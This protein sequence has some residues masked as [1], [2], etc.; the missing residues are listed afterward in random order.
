MKKIYVIILFIFLLILAGIFLLPKDETN[1][2]YII[3]QSYGFV[4]KE[5]KKAEIDVYTKLKRS[6]IDNAEAN[7]YYLT[8]DTTRYKLSGIEVYKSKLNGY[9]IYKISFTLPDTK[10]DI[11]TTNAYLSI[12][13]ER[14]LEFHLSSLSI[15]YNKSLE[16]SF[17]TIYATYGYINGALMLVGINIELENKYNILSYFS[18]NDFSY[19]DMTCIL[20]ESLQNN[21]VNIK[22]LL[23]NYNYN[24]V[25]FEQMEIKSN[26][27]FIPV[28]YNDLLMIKHGYIILKLDGQKYI[29]NDFDFIFN[30]LDISEYKDYM[31]EV[32]YA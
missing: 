12:V 22:E 28:T 16:L 10:N 15:I 5:D 20:Q 2:H 11:N 1:D 6:I 24:K 8:I 17:N 23:P 4:Y 9:S 3:K 29:I 31:Q 27:L 13:G 21:E 30:N 14:T 32:K 25:G 19:T 7:D 18:I 26:K